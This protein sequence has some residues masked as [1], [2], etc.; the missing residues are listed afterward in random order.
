[1][2][3]SYRRVS[4]KLPFKARVCGSSHT[5]IK[6]RTSI[7]LIL[8]AMALA[9]APGWE[10]LPYDILDSILEDLVSIEDCIRFSVVC[11][12]WR[13]VAVDN[14]RQI[15]GR[16]NRYDRL[17]QQQLP[18]LILPSSGQNN[19]S[20]RRLYNAIQKRFFDFQIRVPVPF[21]AMRICGSSQGWLIMMDDD[22]F[23]VALFNPFSHKF[24]DFPPIHR[25]ESYKGLLDR[26]YGI[27]NMTRFIVKCALSANPTV[28]NDY[29]LMILCDC[30]VTV[31]LAFFKSGDK[32]W[33]Y[34]DHST[35][36]IQNCHE[37]DAPSSPVSDC[38]LSCITDIIFYKHQF[39]ALSYWGQ[40]FSFDL[41]NSTG[42]IVKTMTS[43]DSFPWKTY[44]VESLEGGD[45]LKV[46]RIY[47]HN[48]I[49]RFKVY[50]LMESHMNCKWIEVTNLGNFALFLGDNHSISVLASDYLGCQSNSIY[51]CSDSYLYYLRRELKE[52][53]YISVFNLE[54]GMVVENH[55]FDYAQETNMPPPIWIS[56]TCE[57]TS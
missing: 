30:L 32:D 9:P 35:C 42:I 17:N 1:M 31:R 2:W 10:S 33:T 23:K 6:A 36:S 22:T 44:L 27:R 8:S 21:E 49:K 29:D 40:L 51:F 25:L 11:R 18:L 50:K 41:N 39:R 20:G 4:L 34:V 45:I 13:S 48:K 14:F 46:E 24:I 7:S 5:L 28:T 19:R 12:T 26:V 56:P 3:L 47:S 43:G 38:V 15:R 16:N 37:T 57:L 54:D 53:H 55:T 52:P